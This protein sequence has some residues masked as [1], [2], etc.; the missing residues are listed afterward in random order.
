[1]SVNKLPLLSLFLGLLL[2]SC[3]PTPTPNYAPRSAWI[4]KF[5]EEPTCQPPCWENVI[6]GEMTM[7][8]TFAVLWNN[9]E[10]HI[11]QYWTEPIG[12]SKEKSISWKFIQSN[13]G[14]IAFSDHEGEILQFIRLDLSNDQLLTIADIISVF[15][16][17]TKVYLS[18]CRNERDCVVEFLYIEL[19]MSASTNV[20]KAK[21]RNNQGYSV[22][23]SEET[24]ITRLHLHASGE[25]HY[26]ED[27]GGWAD[28][29]TIPNWNGYG[30]YLEKMPAH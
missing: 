7:D 28:Y 9:P 24:K 26:R 12:S 6:P 18:D 30:E 10:I 2:T 5:L 3:I 8:E 17:P 21:Y 23:I 16:L 19:G 13:D 22:S 20:L 4:T 1:M 25:E 29:D 11:T 14:G 27:L 15:G